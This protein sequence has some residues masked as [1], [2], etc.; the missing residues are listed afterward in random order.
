MQMASCPNNCAEHMLWEASLN[1]ISCRTDA[2][3]LQ[4][5]IEC[6]LT[7]DE[8]RTR[9]AAQLPRY[10]VLSLTVAARTICLTNTEPVSGLWSH[11][12][13][14]PLGPWLPESPQVLNCRLEPLQ[15]SGQIKGSVTPQN[16]KEP[17]APHLRTGSPTVHLV[18]A[19]CP[20]PE[21]T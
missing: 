4:L 2:E 5:L 10:L 17:M 16:R 8:R 14:L 18:L 12:Q 13:H 3:A 11:E 15:W 19:P 7:S 6:Q 20:G 21:Q 9:R 1:Y